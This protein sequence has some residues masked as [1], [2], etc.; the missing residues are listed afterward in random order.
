MVEGRRFSELSPQELNHQLRTVFNSL[1]TYVGDVNPDSIPEDDDIEMLNNLDFSPYEMFGVL[2][3]KDIKSFAGVIKR[4]KSDMTDKLWKMH[5][6]LLAASELVPSLQAILVRRFRSYPILGFKESEK[7][8]LFGFKILRFDSKDGGI[9]D[10]EEA[11]EI[12]RNIIREELQTA[13][14]INKLARRIWPEDYEDVEN[15]LLTDEN[16]DLRQAVIEFKE[17][18]NDEP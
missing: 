9:F 12:S 1:P 15:E 16:K 8:E 2:D 3:Y 7:E 4:T 17:K 18:Y 10:P 5:R 13:L 6:E 11:K 14:S